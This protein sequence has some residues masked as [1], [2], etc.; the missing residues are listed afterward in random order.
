[1]KKFYK[2][3]DKGI[4]AVEDT[5]CVISFAAIVCI[6]VAHVFFRYVLRSGI[7]WSDEVVQ[8]LMVSMVMF[9]TA[10]AVR[11]D[12]HT[13]L[14]SFVDRLPPVGRTVVRTLV[15]LVSLGFLIMFFISSFEFTATT[16]TLKTVMLRIPRKYCYMF[17]P[18]GAGLSIY[19]F[20]KTAGHRIFHEPKEY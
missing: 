11:V 2:A 10:R 20:I 4:A 14:Q 7:L 6:V 18:L 15:T 1:M 5:G 16:G 8:I 19:E 13:E 17:L 9:G 3:V 12:G